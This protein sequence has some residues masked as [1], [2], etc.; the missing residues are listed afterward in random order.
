MAPAAFLTRKFAANGLSEHWGS[1]GMRSTG[2]V[3]PSNTE[4]RIP[5]LVAIGVADVPLADG[6]GVVGGVTCGGVVGPYPLCPVVVGA[7]K[8]APSCDLDG[9]RNIYHTPPA[10]NSTTITHATIFLISM[11]RSIPRNPCRY[12]HVLLHLHAQVVYTYIQ[13]PVNKRF[14]LDPWK[15]TK[16]NAHGVHFVSSR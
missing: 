1:G 6:G 16:H 2:H 7:E 9:I 13:K 12:P 10:R 14:A 15:S 4:P 3:G 5:E 8:F 11:I